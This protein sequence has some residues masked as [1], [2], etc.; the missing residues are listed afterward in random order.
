MRGGGWEVGEFVGLRT[1][2][3]TFSPSGH[4]VPE[5]EN[6]HRGQ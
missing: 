2:I 4:V 6:K 5:N 3:V 1:P